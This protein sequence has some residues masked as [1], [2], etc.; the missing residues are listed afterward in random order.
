MR[1][2]WL[3]AFLFQRFPDEFEGRIDLCPIDHQRGCQSYDRMM[4][5]LGEQTFFHQF[6]AN[7]PSFRFF[8]VDLDPDE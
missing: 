2:R 1:L 5:F 6:E 7:V 4:G 3:P 8:R